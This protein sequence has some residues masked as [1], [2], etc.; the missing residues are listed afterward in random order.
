MA[1]T[2]DAAQAQAIIS[3]ML[4]AVDAA[5]LLADFHRRRAAELEGNIGQLIGQ[6][7]AA[8][9]EISA[10][11]AEKEAAKASA[12]PAKPAAPKA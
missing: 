7:T 2:V 8:R 5:T 10:L 1:N 9:A 4:R 6:L 11:K 12:A 3:D